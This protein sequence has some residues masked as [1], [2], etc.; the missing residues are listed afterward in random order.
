MDKAH[1]MEWKHF[2]AFVGIMKDS[3]KVSGKTCLGWHAIISDRQIPLFCPYSSVVSATEWSWVRRLPLLSMARKACNAD[4]P[5]KLP[6]KTK[7]W[8]QGRPKRFRIVLGLMEVLNQSWLRKVP[9]QLP[10]SDSG[11]ESIFRIN[12][13]HI[14]S[15]RK[16]YELTISCG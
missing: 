9:E 2:A 11:M 16:R 12:K 10:F 7:R 3:Q 6:A 1:Q 14:S 4:R 5:S 8:P 15:F 13:G